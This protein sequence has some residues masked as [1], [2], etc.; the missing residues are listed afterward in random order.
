MPTYVVSQTLIIIGMLLVSVGDLTTYILGAPILLPLGLG[1]QGPVV[2]TILS[3]RVAPEN[4][5]KFFAGNSLMQLL[6]NAVCVYVITNFWLNVAPQPDGSH[7]PEQI[8]R[9]TTA[10][11][12]GAVAYLCCVIMMVVTFGINYQGSA[13][14]H[15][16]ERG[17]FPTYKTDTRSG[18]RVIDE[19]AIQK[20]RTQSLLELGAMKG[21]QVM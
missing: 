12:G 8:F 4:A 19:D 10:W 18:S 3:S 15:G 20:K 21:G 9:M 5:G 11:Y 17:A 1:M 7:L 13:A 16:G 6:G 2:P 14:E